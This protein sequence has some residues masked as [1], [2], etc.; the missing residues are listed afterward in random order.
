MYPLR[1]AGIAPALKFD[2]RAVGAGL[3]IG[4]SD[5]IMAE[6]TAARNDAARIFI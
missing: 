4:V 2:R 1:G 3:L 6:V 5:R